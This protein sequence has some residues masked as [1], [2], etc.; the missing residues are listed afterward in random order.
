MKGPPHPRPK[1]KTTANRNYWY[2][3]IKL[4]NGKRCALPDMNTKKT[5]WKKMVTYPPT[6]AVT[7]NPL[8]VKGKKN[9]LTKKCES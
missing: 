6:N 8:G 1:Q 7:Q 5:K 9:I 2:F 4:Y 3:Q